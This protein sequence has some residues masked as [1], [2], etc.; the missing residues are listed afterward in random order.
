LGGRY[1]K[2]R[3]LAK[4]M[5]KKAKDTA[6]KKEEANKKLEK[7]DELLKISEDVNL[8]YE[9]AEEMVSEGKERLD[10]KQF[11][12]AISLISD[13]VEDLRQLNLDYI[14]EQ[15]S[16]IE[17]FLKSAGKNKKYESL[18]DEM[19]K[20]KEL[21][22]N[23][24]FTEAHEKTEEINKKAE[25]IMEEGIKKDL[26]NIESLMNIVEERGEDKGKA[27]EI[28]SD[29][30]YAFEGGE[31]ERAIELINECKEILGEKIKGD[32][33]EMIREL[34]KERDQLEDEGVDVEGIS[35]KLDK[36]T[37][38]ENDGEFQE[39]L[40]LVQNT[41][42]EIDEKVS[43]LVNKKLN[44]FKEQMEEA[45]DIGAD[46]TEL[47]DIPKKVSSFIDEGEL[48]KANSLL[49]E[50]FE[51]VEDAKFQ[52]VLKTIAESKED[53]IKAKNIGSDIGE[54]MSLLNKARDSLR[55]GDYRGALKWAKAGR[56]KVK[57]LVGEHEKI[58]NEISQKNEYVEKL[59]KKIDVNFVES[60]N[61]LSEA[62]E[63]LDENEYEKAEEKIDEV[64]EKIEKTAYE[65]LMDIIESVEVT[66]LTAE[67]IEIDIDDYRLKLEESIDKTKDNEFLE[68]ANIA[69]EI[70]ENLHQTIGDELNNRIENMHDKISSVSGKIENDVEDR[71]NR[72]LEESRNSLENESYRDSWEF[73]TKAEKELEM[74]QKAKA[75]DYFD[76][77]SDLISIVSNLDVEGINIEDLKDKL[78]ESEGYLKNKKFTESIEKSESV[79]SR[80]N[81]KLDKKADDLFSEAKKEV[82]K[83]K[84]I[85]IDIEKSRERL[86]ECKKKIKK[87]DYAEAIRIAYEIRENNKKERKRRNSINEYISNVTN[88]LSELQKKEK[89]ANVRDA[90]DVLKKAKKEVR[91]EN[92]SEAKRLAEKARNKIDEIKGRKAIKNQIDE[93]YDQIEKVKGMDVEFEH[94]E[95]NY[96]KIENAER[97]I[98]K[99]KNKK[100]LDKIE[101]VRKTINNHIEKTIESKIKN[102]KDQ[103]DTLE[104]IGIDFSKSDDLLD[105][106]KSLFN[107]EWYW[108]AYDKLEDAEESIENK[109]KKSKKA[110][111]QLKKV[112]DIIQESKSLNT[113]VEEPEQII[114]KVEEAIE[115]NNYQY[116]LEELELA[117]R[118]V[119]NAEKKRVKNILNT[120]RKK[121]EKARSKGLDI[122]LADNIM[123]RAEKA[124]DE[125]DY[126]EAI[127]LAMQSEGEIEKIE[128]QQKIAKRTILNANKKL[129][130]AE[131]KGINIDRAKML[132]N[133][134]KRSYKEGI[135]VKAFDSALKASD[136]LDMTLKS[137]NESKDNIDKIKEMINEF[138]E[139]G[140]EVQYL[141]NN[142]EKIQN[143]L[144]SGKYEESYNLSKET[145]NNNEKLEPMVSELASKIETKL[146]ELEEKGRD[147]N[148]GRKKIART[149]AVIDVESPYYLLKLIEE[150][151]EESG[152]RKEEKYKSL[153]KEVGQLIKKARKFGASVTSVRKYIKEAKKFESEND[154]DKAYELI[155]EAQNRVEEALKP[156]SPDLKI[157][158][159]K[160]PTINKWNTINV[161]IK[162]EGKG[163]A[164][165]PK[166]VVDGAEIKNKDLPNMLKGKDN[167]DVKIKIKPYEENIE[168]K[169]EG[170]R[171]FDNKKF[172]DKV[173]ID[174]SEGFDYMK[175]EEED[176]CDICGEK[177][178]KGDEIVL[179]SCGNMIHNRCAL[180]EKVCPDCGTDLEE[181]EE[182]EDEEEVSRRVSLG[183]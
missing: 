23:D 66:L 18:R 45:E 173:G 87:K 108:E 129:K 68:A 152:I 29:A 178:E 172:E 171:I 134:S 84:K 86:I 4:E 60:R 19:E 90:R 37:K 147:I 46:L 64:E 61:I 125:G 142:L 181:V 80:L 164:K 156:Y 102:I 7:V 3:Q 50:A 128:L 98:D 12:E 179:C 83:A 81:S 160:R 183:I 106:A 143:K 85:G 40:D 17:N 113:D 49:D 91:K 25:N 30:K 47:E 75:E 159:G 117:K 132:L 15:L 21:I 59:S 93:V 158:V 110:R 10:N 99:G 77:A 44:V 24:D 6:K 32:I 138:E 16:H 74:T 121:I 22:K 153:V 94:L 65:G 182:V 126:R 141:K 133:N 180:K 123:R 82:L 120:F 140:M 67:D 95:E 55:G 139:E 71:V 119:R 107:D 56:E 89:A 155:K 154:I 38:L 149:R 124:M 69:L 170:I 97:L 105:E 145:I 174:V 144:D 167:L 118:K 35:E 79:V 41:S 57:E 70:R 176:T 175:A 53:F 28:Y 146:D 130:R 114:E 161:V 62:E 27:E 131:E 8:D 169:A 31:Y 96:N 52:K 36:A 122:A 103:L 48:S 51:K 177:I 88:E 26:S 163:V 148:K 73:I 162:N 136:K 54:P 2:A 42:R 76:K 157:E 14:D 166:I 135:Y 20:A 39:A 109:R 1:L 115:N 137:F 127:N 104:G 100:A 150:A 11:D 92:Y 72:F 165:D 33:D 78:D 34:E 101:E 116:A 168:I 151:K 111:D 58:K 5:E 13:A 63:M 43:N 112:K 9:E